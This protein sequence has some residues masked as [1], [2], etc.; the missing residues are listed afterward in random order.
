MK[1]SFFIKLSGQRLAISAFVF[2]KHLEFVLKDVD[3]FV[4]LQGIFNL[5]LYD[6]KEL[7]QLCIQL[8]PR[9][10]DHHLLLVVVHIVLSRVVSLPV[11]SCL[12]L[13]SL[14]HSTN[15]Q[16]DFSGFSVVCYV[17]AEVLLLA[18]VNGLRLVLISKF[19]DRLSE[20]FPLPGNPEFQ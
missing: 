16:P 7:L 17:E 2:A 19:G 12:E 15:L 18:A 4:G 14:L 3:S 11:K 5:S 9:L 1:V 13:H 8:L 6:V 10:V 20:L